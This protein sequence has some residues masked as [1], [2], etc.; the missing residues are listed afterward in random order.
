M[1][2]AIASAAARKHPEIIRRMA[3]DGHLV[4]N[5]SWSHPAP[6]T[7]NAAQYLRD[8][9]SGRQEL[10]DILGSPVRQFRPPHGHLTARTLI[11][12]W[13]NATQVML[14]NVDPKDYLAESITTVSDRLRHATLRA[15]DVVLL[16][17]T[18]PATAHGL[19][20]ILTV[21]SRV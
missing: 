11:G 20:G 10:E 19:A 1:R 4:G 14:W 2:M 12:L 18:I 8:V 13:S 15:G 9:A 7:M 3:Q 17:D 21:V 5:H 6:G 16:H